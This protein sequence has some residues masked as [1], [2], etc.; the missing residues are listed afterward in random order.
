M[1]E[2]ISLGYVLINPPLH[3][4]EFGLLSLKYIVSVLCQL[5][6]DSKVSPFLKIYQYNFTGGILA[7]SSFVNNFTAVPEATRSKWPKSYEQ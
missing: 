6:K 4:T 7:T 3:Q 2:P 1:E 5:T